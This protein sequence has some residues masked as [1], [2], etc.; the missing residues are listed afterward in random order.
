MHSLTL[1]SAA[2][3]LASLTSASPVAF[4]VPVPASGPSHKT[5]TVH[6]NASK[7]V[8]KNGP[9][10]LANTYNKYRKAIPA[11]VAKAAAAA[12]D[13]S[14]TN[15]PEPNDEVRDLGAAFPFP[16]LDQHL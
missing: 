10:A 11:N 15:T 7:P 16:L 1:V 4:P 9:F 12:A 8:F 13:G 14:V 6:Q 2:L 5:F 3:A